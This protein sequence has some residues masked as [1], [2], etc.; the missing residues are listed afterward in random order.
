VTKH[1]ILAAVEE[2]AR[3]QFSIK[4]SDRRFSRSID[5]FEEGYVDS[6]G[7]IELIEFLEQT[8]VV[9]IPEEDLFSPEFSTIDG[10]AQIVVRNRVE[11][12]VAT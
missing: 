8:F 6:I 3:R 7:V 10:I 4:P 12:Q 11:K 2:F 9:E 1:E 5:L